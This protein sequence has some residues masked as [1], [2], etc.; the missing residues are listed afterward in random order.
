M[1]VYIV[2]KYWCNNGEAED[3]WDDTE[4]IGV[5]SSFDSARNEILDIYN[6]QIRD[7]ESGL[8]PK[9]PEIGLGYYER[10]H[11]ISPYREYK[12]TDGISHVE[13]HEG[14][15]TLWYTGNYDY[16]IREEVVHG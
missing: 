15:P 9:D 6:K 8:N 7:Y 11:K 2:M 1:K 13:W 12:T 10:D 4:F 14:E 3:D 16:S 5:F